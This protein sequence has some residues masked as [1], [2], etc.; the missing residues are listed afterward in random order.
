M[1]EYLAV[2][3]SH[4]LMRR[5]PDYFHFIIF[6]HTTWTPFL[7]AVDTFASP[8]LVLGSV[9]GVGHPL[10]QRADGAGTSR[11]SPCLVSC[12]KPWS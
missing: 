6:L 12:T 2:L 3:A 1:I 11:T 10:L 8:E 5:Y 9:G 7:S 4:C